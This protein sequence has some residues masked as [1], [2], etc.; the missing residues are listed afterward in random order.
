[1][2]FHAITL[3]PHLFWLWTNET[4]SKAGPPRVTFQHQFSTALL[5]PSIDWLQSIHRTNL[6]AVCSVTLSKKQ[7]CK[8]VQCCPRSIESNRHFKG[9]APESQGSFFIGKYM[10][11]GN[12][13][14]LNYSAVTFLSTFISH[15]PKHNYHEPEKPVGAAKSEGSSILSSLVAPRC[16]P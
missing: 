12:N 6:R 14:I 16:T 2:K 8:W 5:C 13:R 1:M 3:T 4:S 7:N 10:F 15:Y 11:C 9:M